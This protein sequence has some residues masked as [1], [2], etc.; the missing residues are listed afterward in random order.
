M[1]TVLALYKARYTLSVVC[2]TFTED[3][4]VKLKIKRENHTIFLLYG[5]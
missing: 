3:S 2:D 5:L 4:L 1:V